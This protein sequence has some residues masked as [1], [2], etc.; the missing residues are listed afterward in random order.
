MR[1]VHFGVRHDS[2]LAL[3]AILTAAL[4]ALP[5]RADDPKPAG[6]S[7]AA[8][9]ATAPDVFGDV[10]KAA[11][12]TKD[13]LGFRGKGTWAR[14]PRPPYELPFFD[15]LLADATSTYEFTRTMGN[16]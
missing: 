9:D 12:L 15:D 3:A 16:A 7:P 2:P 13:D 8:A 1:P 6:A 5:A 14:W 4:A 11:G 10:V